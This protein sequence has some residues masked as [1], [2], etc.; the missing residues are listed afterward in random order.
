MSQFVENLE[1]KGDRCVV[2]LGMHRSGSSLVA[3]LF[4]EWGVFLG[5]KLM[6]ADGINPDGYFE[7]LEFVRM[8]E[9]LL[10]TR[11]ASWS[12]PEMVTEVS[13]EIRGEVEALVSRSKKR[14]WGWKD[15]RTAFT[16]KIYEPNLEN[17]LFVVCRRKKGSVVRS[18]MRSHRHLFPE[19]QRTEEYMGRLYDRYYEA[20]GEVA[21]DYPRLDVH[22]EDLAGSRYFKT[23]LRHFG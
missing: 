7:N 21:K 16:F 13:A 20:I 15:N 23:E 19:A 14:L 22:Y 8:N 18:L 11:D 4:H 2:I 17:V 9:R 6:A 12:Q 10:A 1:R 5:E 3:R